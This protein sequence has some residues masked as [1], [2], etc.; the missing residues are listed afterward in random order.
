MRMSTPTSAVDRPRRDHHGSTAARNPTAPSSTWAGDDLLGPVLA[1]EP[2]VDQALV[3]AVAVVA[4][5]DAAGGADE[6]SGDGPEHTGDEGFGEQLLELVGLL[7]GPVEAAQVVLGVGL[8]GFLLLVAA[9]GS[10]KNPPAATNRMPMTTAMS[11]LHRVDH[12]EDD[13]DR[14]HRDDRGRTEPDPA[15]ALVH[16]LH[17]VRA[18]R[19]GWPRGG[20]RGGRRGRRRTPGPR[21]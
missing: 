17:V 6:S 8:V 10:T 15:P 3:D 1:G 18:D 11:D 16:G 20:R 13:A 4:G 5:E 7:D 21:P 12:A 14:H 9:R 2:G 19:P